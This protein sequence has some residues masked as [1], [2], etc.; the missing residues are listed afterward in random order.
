MRSVYREDCQNYAHDQRSDKNADLQQLALRLLC[1]HLWLLCFHSTFLLSIKKVKS[2][3]SHYLPAT[4]LGGSD[5]PL[6]LIFSLILFVQ[7]RFCTDFVQQQAQLI[8]LILR[9]ALIGLA[10]R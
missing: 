10:F 3:G 4:T 8:S 6:F 9:A 7:K 1:A 2:R 5:R